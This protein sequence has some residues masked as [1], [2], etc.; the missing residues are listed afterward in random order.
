MKFHYLLPMRWAFSQFLFGLIFSTLLVTGSVPSWGQPSETVQYSGWE[1]NNMTR[2]CGGCRP[3][4]SCSC[5]ISFYPIHSRHSCGKHT[6]T[7]PRSTTRILPKTECHC[8]NEA[9]RAYAQVWVKLQSG[10]MSAE[11]ALSKLSQHLE[12]T[13]HCDRWEDCENLLRFID[14]EIATQRAATEH[15]KED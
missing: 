7:P 4:R 12:C 11:T 13:D 3:N 8:I 14:Q 15:Q 1:V 9:I 5:R 2:I 6:K 10:D